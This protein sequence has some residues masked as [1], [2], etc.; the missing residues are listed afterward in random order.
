MN[1]NV[2]SDLIVWRGDRATIVDT[3]DFDVEISVDNEGDLRISPS[4]A[5]CYFNR[6]S[7]GALAILVNRYVATGQ[8][9]NP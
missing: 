5:D 1:E 6:E 7:A 9:K 3:L 4:D 8:I 2:D